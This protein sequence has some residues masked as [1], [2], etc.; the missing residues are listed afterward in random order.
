VNI[1]VFVVG[2]FQENTYLLSDASSGEAVFIDPGDDG[3]ALADIV[4]QRNLKLAAIW[5]TH[6]HIDHIGGIAALKRQFDVPVYL[7]PADLAIY[8]RATDVA[9]MYQ[10][11]FEQPP[12]PDKGLAEGDMVSLGSLRFH[13][14]HVPGHAPGH[15]AFFG[16]GVLF[17][18]DC[19]FAGSVGRTDLPL[20]DAAAFATTLERL[21]ALPDETRVLPGHG[22]E[23]SI[24]EERA[25]NPFL[26]GVARPLRR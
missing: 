8:A 17:G 21:A 5:L 6:A 16:H 25:T 18:G 4:R 10:L 20:S 7:H 1:A 3:A 23:T 26:T 9:E 19:L 12:L 24:R 22:P 11:P 2:A 15:V 14:M 13:V